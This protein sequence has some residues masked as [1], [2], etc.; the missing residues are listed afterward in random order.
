MEAIKVSELLKKY[1]DMWV[2]LN[3]KRTEVL[4]SAQKLEDAIRLAKNKSSEQ[5]ILTYVPRLDLDYVG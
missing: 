2:A 4:A 1:A 3:Q 5:P